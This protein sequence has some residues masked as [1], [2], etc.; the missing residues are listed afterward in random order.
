MCLG[1]TNWAWITYRV[2]EFMPIILKLN[3]FLIQNK[4][5]DTFQFKIIFFVNLTAFKTGLFVFGILIE[6]VL[7]VFRLSTKYYQLLKIIDKII[8]I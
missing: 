2:S 8:I 4:I 3:I 6:K 5:N 1:E 7:N